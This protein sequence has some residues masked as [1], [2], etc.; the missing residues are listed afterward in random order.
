MEVK[1]RD[2]MRAFAKINI[3][4]KS[5]KFEAQDIRQGTEQ[6]VQDVATLTPFCG[7]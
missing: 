4:R 6:A 3:C 7:L 5:H 1:R 2:Y